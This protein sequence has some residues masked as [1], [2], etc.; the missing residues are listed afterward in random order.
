MVVR[1][2]GGLT[3]L[4]NTSMPPP[5]TPTKANT[6]CSTCTQAASVSNPT[7]ATDAVPQ[8]QSMHPDPTGSPHTAA[9]VSATGANEGKDNVQ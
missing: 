6:T 9:W 7:T 3:V 4:Q 1:G 5:L 2:G 8:Q